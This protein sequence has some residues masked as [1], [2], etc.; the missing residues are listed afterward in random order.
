MLFLL[1]VALIA[2]PAFYRRSRALGAASGKLASIPFVTLGAI[3]AV[4]YVARIVLS[5]AMV[6]VGGSLGV[7]SGILLAFDFFVILAY[8]ALIRAFWVALNRVVK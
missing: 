8:A 3:L 5:W 4:R 6:T 7:T 1:I 2:T